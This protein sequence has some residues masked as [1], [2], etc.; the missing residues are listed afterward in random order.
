MAW[1]S[2][3]VSASPQSQSVPVGHTG[4]LL[5]GYSIEVMPRTAA[6]IKDFRSLLPAGTRIYVAHIEGTPLKEMVRTARRLRQE[7]FAVMPHITARTLR[8]QSE[9]DTMLGRY[10]YEADV[11]E[12][13][14]L[15]GGASRRHGEFSHSMELLGS[16]VFERRGFVELHVA[17][18]PEGNRDIDSDGST[19]QVDRALLAKQDYAGNSSANMTIVTQFAFDPVA[20]FRWTERISK[21]GV[22]LPVRIGVAGPARLQTMMKFALACGVGASMRVLQRR[23]RDLSLL[24]RPFE[25]TDMITGLE[26]LW[27]KHPE[28]NV[29]GIHFFPLGGIKACVD[30]AN[31]QPTHDARRTN[32]GE[33]H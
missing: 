21:L 22:R 23:S 6:K 12:A 33:D 7:G 16:G 2:M 17:G 27:R 15:A 31:K 5:D 30:W 9:L 8:S 11:N 19:T 28:S 13:L 3:P 29:E 32:S 4:R 10:R 20:V 24:L 25:P 1:Q 26:G 14:I 18:H